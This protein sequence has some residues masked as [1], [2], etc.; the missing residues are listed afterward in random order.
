MLFK[1]SVF[2]NMEKYTIIIFYFFSKCSNTPGR[3][4]YPMYLNNIKKI[5][6]LINRFVNLFIL[7]R[8]TL[9]YDG[10]NVCDFK[11]K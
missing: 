7:K 1:K 4:E 2:I 9:N 11:E 10:T 6:K 3:L 8:K 5:Q